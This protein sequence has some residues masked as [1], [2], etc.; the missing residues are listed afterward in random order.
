MIERERPT[1]K[2]NMVKRKREMMEGE[3]I[4]EEAVV[5]LVEIEID[6]L[7]RKMMVDTLELNLARRSQEVNSKEVT[8]MES[9]TASNLH[10]P[11]PQEAV[12]KLLEE[13][14]S[15]PKGVEKLL[16]SSTRMI[17]QL[18]DDSAD[19]IPLSRGRYL[20]N[21]SSRCRI[22]LNCIALLGPSF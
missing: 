1:R 4:E 14:T 6:L 5:D 7:Q 17:S 19:R 13:P 11:S 10:T 15:R 12:A 16:W 9:L 22:N 8:T 3:I 18:C 21:V 2:T 20:I